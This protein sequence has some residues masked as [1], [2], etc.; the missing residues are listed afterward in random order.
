MSLG[1]MKNCERCG[2]VFV[3]TGQICQDCIKAEEQ[4]FENVHHFLRDNPN[5]TTKEIAETLDVDEELIIKFLKQG[6]I[7]T[8]DQEATGRC[9][10]CGAEIKKGNYCMKCLLT[11]KEQMSGASDTLG[12]NASKVKNAVHSQ[13]MNI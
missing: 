10:K 13:D 6:R 1:G 11:M 8:S 7:K 2:K 9:S 12:T 4:I 3:G 5:S